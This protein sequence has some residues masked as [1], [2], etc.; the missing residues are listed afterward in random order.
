MTTEQPS[1]DEGGHS[2]GKIAGIVIG[3]C[4][5]A[6]IVLIGVGLV[7]KFKPWKRRQ[8]CELC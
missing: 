4:L 5:G 7:I 1:S 2:G 8:Q 3:V 6:A